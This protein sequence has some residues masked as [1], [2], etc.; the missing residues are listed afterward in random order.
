MAHPLMSLSSRSQ[1]N[2]PKILNMSKIRI[3]ICQSSRGIK[4]PSLIS[5]K[6]GGAGLRFDKI[7]LNI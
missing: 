3:T 7:F 5:R 2:V 6:V 1:G 4:T